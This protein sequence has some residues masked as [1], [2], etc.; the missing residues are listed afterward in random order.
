MALKV[1]CCEIFDGPLYPNRLD[2]IISIGVALKN[3]IESRS[4]DLCMP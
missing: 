1:I 2:S 4:T 3:D